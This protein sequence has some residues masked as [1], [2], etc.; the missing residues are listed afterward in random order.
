MSINSIFQ[1]LVPKDKKFFPLFEEASSNL[2]ELASNLHEAVNLP[3]KEREVLFQKIDELEQRG[4]DIT[5]QTNLELSRNFITPFDREDIHTLITSIDNVADY[6]HGAASRMRLYQVDKITKSIRKMTE[7]NLEACQNIDSA[8]KELSNLKNMNIIKDACAR[9]NKLENKS[10]NVYN[11]AVFEIF[12]NETD[13]K[14]IIKYKEVLSVLE[15]A[16]DKCKSVANILESISV[17]HS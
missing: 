12:E 15:S 4:E 11:K 10:D 17:K 1:F 13:A 14:N 9:I 3:L 5:R 8:V 6:L 7:I 16:T 2:I